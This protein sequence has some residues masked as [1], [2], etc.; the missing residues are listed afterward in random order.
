MPYFDRKENTFWMWHYFHQK[1]YL[2]RIHLFQ[3]IHQFDEAYLMLLIEFDELYIFDVWIQ[4]HEIVD[5]YCVHWSEVKSHF[6]ER[7]FN[8]STF[9]SPCNRRMWE[10][11]SRSILFSPFSCI[12]HI[13]IS[14]PIIVWHSKFSLELF[15]FNHVQSHG[16]FLVGW[17]WTHAKIALH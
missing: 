4:R 1:C 13:R 17:N 7:K 3:M 5:C 10:H 16:F 11:F 15:I 6:T 9:N 12:L 8:Y 14:H 2:Y